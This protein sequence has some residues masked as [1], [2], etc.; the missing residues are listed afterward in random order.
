MTVTGH[1]GNFSRMLFFQFQCALLV[2][3][4]ADHHFTAGKADARHLRERKQ[5]LINLPSLHFSK[6]AKR[7]PYLRSPKA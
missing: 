4:V 6:P 3:T 7:R 5:F 2:K 1:F